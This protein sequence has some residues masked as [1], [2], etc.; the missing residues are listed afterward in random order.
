MTCWNHLRGCVLSAVLFIGF[1]AMAGC[2]SGQSPITPTEKNPEQPIT[3]CGNGNKVKIKIK[4][5]WKTDIWLE[6]NQNKQDQ[7]NK[8]DLEI[9]LIP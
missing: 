4:Q 6:G 7:E 1:F 5:K 9:P 8:A 3:I 2:Q